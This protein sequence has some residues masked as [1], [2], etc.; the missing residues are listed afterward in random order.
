MIPYGMINWLNRK[1]GTLLRCRDPRHRRAKFFTYLVQ[2]ILKRPVVVEDR[3]GFSLILLPQERLYSFFYNGYLGA[4]EIGEQEF[5]KKT[6][7]PGMTV[8]D[9]GANIG[10]FTLL[11]ASLVGLGGK[12][13]AFEPCSETLQRLRAH[14]I[15][16]GFPDVVTEQSLV[17]SS[18]AEKMPFNVYSEGRSVHNTMGNPT[19][20]VR[21]A[22][23]VS[24]KPVRQDYLDT[25][26]IDRYCSEHGIASIDYL[27]VDVEGAELE[28]FQG[29]R[30]MLA[31]KAVRHIQFEISQPMLQGMKR[32]SSEVFRFL[33]RAGYICCPI[34]ERGELLAP[35]EDTDRFFAN[36]I[37]V[38]REDV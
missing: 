4:S 9:I 3:N 22:P 27:K 23:G 5:C 13:V 1:T 36:F 6:I 29:C 33:A 15:L 19:L 18:H 35:V 20:F 8:F 34:S 17:F 10:Q 14:L 26:T 2:K 37:A 12:V 31:R 32:E 24:E 7:K 11:F 28:V 25:V 30:E 21:G 16:N 38:P